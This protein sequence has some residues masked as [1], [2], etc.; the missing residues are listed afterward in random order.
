MLKFLHLICGTTLFGV[1]IASFFYIALSIYKNDKALTQ[2]ALKTS[3]FGDGIILVMTIIQFITAQHLVVDGHFTLAIPWIF[4]AYHAFALVVLLW[5]CQFLI[6]F[7]YLSKSS[8]SPTILKLYYF[9]NVTIILIFLIII[10]D[11]VTQSTW[12]DFLFKK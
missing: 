8:C 1:M 7:F 5:L 12:F 11:A 6:K 9:F 3:Y 10:H 4:I 2:Y